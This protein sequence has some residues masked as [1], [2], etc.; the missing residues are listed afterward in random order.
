VEVEQGGHSSSRSSRNN[1][2]QSSKRSSR[3]RCKG[4]SRVEGRGRTAGP[5]CCRPAVLSCV[6]LCKCTHPR[7]V[8]YTATGVSVDVLWGRL[9]P[10]LLCK[11]LCAC[12]G[13]HPKT[14]SGA[15]CTLHAMYAFHAISRP[16]WR[17]NHFT[18]LGATW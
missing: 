17:G 6:V 10:V 18:M 15:G 5:S 7:Y 9:Q 16:L 4:S 3:Q 14:C 12:P 13:G 1:S 8:W 2:K 11:S